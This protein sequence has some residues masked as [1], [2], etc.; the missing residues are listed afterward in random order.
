MSQTAIIGG[1]ALVLM[2]FSSSAAA[3]VAMILMGGDDTGNGSKGS[4]GSNGSNGSGG[5]TTKT[6]DPTTTDSTP[7][8]SSYFN[9]TC[10][11]LGG[12]SDII[13][14][15][16]LDDCMNL[17]RTNSHGYPYSCE[18]LIYSSSFQGHSPFCRIY[19][20]KDLDSGT[21]ICSMGLKT[22]TLN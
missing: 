17:C 14:A 1:G 3:S 11:D 21:D 5:T 4:N 10:D 9:E 20:N 2:L 7:S 19:N 16:N 15:S 6:T 13:S 12:G 8:P 22:Y 18:G